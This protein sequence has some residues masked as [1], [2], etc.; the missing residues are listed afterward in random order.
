MNCPNCNN[1]N[2]KFVYN[3]VIIDQCKSCGGIWLDRGEL[4]L[5]L[6]NIPLLQSSNY[7]LLKNKSCPSRSQI[8]CLNTERLLEKRVMINNDNINLI[9]PRCNVEL[10][11]YTYFGIDLDYCVECNGM[12]FDK[13]EL[14][15]LCKK[16]KQ[17]NSYFYKLWNKIKSLFK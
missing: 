2:V 12:F 6:N 17:C 4:Y 13:G 8:I 16:I 5:I 10:E 1:R 11:D 15:A 14:E 3:G 7:N 9:C